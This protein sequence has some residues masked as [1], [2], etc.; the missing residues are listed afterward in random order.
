[1]YVEEHT[2]QYAEHPTFGYPDGQPEDVDWRG[3]KNQIDA[4]LE[5]ALYHPYASC[6]IVSTPCRVIDLQQA[7]NGLYSSC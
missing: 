2:G 7:S 4:A 6:A 3:A 5:Q 1:M